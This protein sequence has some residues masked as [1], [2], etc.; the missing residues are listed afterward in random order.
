VAIYDAAQAGK[1]SEA[2]MLAV[3]VSLIAMVLLYF[4]NYFGNQKKRT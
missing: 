4:I 2:F 1:D 3:I